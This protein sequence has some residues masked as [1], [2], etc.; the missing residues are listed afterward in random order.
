ML[1]SNVEKSCSNDTV[2]YLE[3]SLACGIVDAVPI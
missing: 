2:N 1:N 3:E